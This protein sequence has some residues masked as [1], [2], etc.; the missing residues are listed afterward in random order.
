MI[1]DSLPVIGMIPRIANG[2]LATGHHMLGMT[3][4]P[5]TGKLV[6]EIIGGRPTHIDPAPFSPVRFS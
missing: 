4:V 6:A 1:W 2:V 3:M 5:A